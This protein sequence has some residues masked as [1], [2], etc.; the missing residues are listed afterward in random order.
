MAQIYK[1]YA[2]ASG[3]D[4]WTVDIPDTSQKIL[5]QAAALESGK[6]RAFNQEIRNQQAYLNGLESKFK[7][8]AQNRTENLK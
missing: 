7:K 4:R 3:I 5:D 1:G 2:Q 6:K 8:E